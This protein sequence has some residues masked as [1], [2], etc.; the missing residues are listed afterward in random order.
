M[1]AATTPIIVKWKSVLCWPVHLESPDV[2][3]EHISSGS[4]D[5]TCLDFLRL[6]HH[7]DLT[8][9]EIRFSDRGVEYYSHVH[10]HLP[11][12]I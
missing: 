2:R 10:G 3:I 4:L 6:M 8:K 9:K 12:D 1:T 11:A 7:V 5:F